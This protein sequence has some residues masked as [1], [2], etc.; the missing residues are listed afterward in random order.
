MNIC[1]WNAQLVKNKTTFLSD[2]VIYNDI[3]IMFLTEAW[4]I[5]SDESV[6]NVHH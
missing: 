4:F 6:V 3:D 1:L 2:Y 5:E